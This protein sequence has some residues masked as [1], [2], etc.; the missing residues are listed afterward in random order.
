MNAEAYA[1]TGDEALASGDVGLAVSL[2]T[3]GLETNHEEHTVGSKAHLAVD[4]EDER[5]TRAMLLLGRAKCHMELEDFRWVDRG[6]YGPPMNPLWTPHGPP[7][8]PRWT[9]DGPLWTP[10]GPLWTLYGS[11]APSATWSLRTLGGWKG[12]LMDPL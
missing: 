8:D 9:P 4:G 6:P 11:A 5:C 12:P 2:F 7:M 10:Y 1:I 3:K